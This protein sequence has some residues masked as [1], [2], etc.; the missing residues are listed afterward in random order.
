[1]NGIDFVRALGL[2]IPSPQPY[3]SRSARPGWPPR[4]APAPTASPA[5]H[6][7]HQAQWEPARWRAEASSRR[8]D[9]F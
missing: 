5:K 8:V 6:W 3:E 1:M 7:T 4:P 2:Q 9:R